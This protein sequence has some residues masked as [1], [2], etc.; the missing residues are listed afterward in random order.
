MSDCLIL[1]QTIITTWK[2]YLKVSLQG[3]AINQ[4]YV[5]KQILQSLAYLR[6]SSAD[7]ITTPSIKSSCFKSIMSIVILH[8]MNSTPSNI[9]ISYRSG[10]DGICAFYIFS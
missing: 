2:C 5:Y 1:I 9:A 7:C 6:K 10:N 4:N 8:A 3:I